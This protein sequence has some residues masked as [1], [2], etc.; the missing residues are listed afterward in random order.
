MKALPKVG[1]TKHWGCVIMGVY[2]NFD[3]MVVIMSSNGVKGLGYG[4][5]THLLSR[6]N[7][8]ILSSIL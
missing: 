3:S 7:P 8:T 6:F 4:V 1:L 5:M 2:T